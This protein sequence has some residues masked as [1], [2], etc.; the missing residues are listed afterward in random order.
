MGLN[1]CLEKTI[2]IS[3]LCGFLVKAHLIDDRIIDKIVTRK[4]P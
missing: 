1:M 2:V 3:V 4:N